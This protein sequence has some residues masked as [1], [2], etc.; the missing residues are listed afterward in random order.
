MNYNE[1]NKVS[2]WKV[3]ITH[4]LRNTYDHKAIAMRPV[5]L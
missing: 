2:S 4:L 5:P 3:Y 1:E